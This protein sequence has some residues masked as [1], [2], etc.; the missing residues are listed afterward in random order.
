MATWVYAVATPG[1]TGAGSVVDHMQMPGPPMVLRRGIDIVV[2]GALLV[3]TFLV[4]DLHYVLN[5]PYWVDEAWVAISDRFPLSQLPDTTSTTPIGWSVLVRLAGTPG[6][7]RARLVPLAFGALTAAAAYWFAADLP[8]RDRWL[9]PLAGA[10]AGFATLLAP[11][12]LIRNDL[13]QY[14]ADAFFGVVVL[15]LLSRLEQSWSRR[16]LIGLAV[17][18]VGGFLFSDAAAFVGMAALVAALV[19]AHGRGERARRAETV[20]VGGAALVALAVIYFVFVARSVVAGL[21]SYWQGYYVPHSSRAPDFVA[22]RTASA[23]AHL[24]QGPAPLALALLLLGLVTL[25]RLGRP[26]VAL[27]LL[28]LW[29]E[30]IGLAVADKYPLLDVR[31]ST[32]VTV[33]GAVVAAVA[34]VQVGSLLPGRS[35]RLALVLCLLAGGLYVNNVSSDIRS[36]LIPV[37]DVRT[38]ARYVAAHRQPQDVVLVNLSSNWGFAYYWSLDEPGRR[39]SDVVTQNYIVDYPAS[40]RIVIASGRTLAPIE[41]A[42]S[43]AVAR[44]KQ[45]HGRVWLVRTHLL[46]PEGQ[47]W[48]R[49]LA[50]DHLGVVPVP[51]AGALTVIAP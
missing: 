19:V 50:A 20:I 5:A 3:S 33:L 37:E 15:I 7:Q 6:S 29:V 47:Y 49:A 8:W 13:K 22:Q 9:S 17:V 41:S 39:P 38:Q 44:A 26:T 11:S 21:T 16:R 48:S 46:D 18:T 34:I 27:A 45:A 51:G 12:L 24:G 25:V 36:R 40:A 14:T 23:L 10:S 43:D 4:H 35:V 42:L 32:F 28:V 1:P 31:T 2:V 30:M